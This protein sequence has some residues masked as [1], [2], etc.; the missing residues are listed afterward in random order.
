MKAIAKGKNG[1]KRTLTSRERLQRSVNQFFA[2]LNCRLSY[3]TVEISTENS[4]LATALGVTFKTVS[5]GKIKIAQKL[6]DILTEAE[7]DVVL[8]H[9]VSHIHLNHLLGTGFFVVARELAKNAARSD[10]QWKYLLTAWDINK[11]LTYWGG[12]LPPFAAVTKEQ[13]LDADASAV[14]L[15]DNKIAAHSALRKLV[16]NNLGTP[17]HTWEVFDTAIPVMTISER[18]SALDDR[19]P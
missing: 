16:G 7:V 11:A 5:F 2:R 12:D 3:V 10:P 8:A 9:E 6:L 17:S 1:F 15:T 18:L 4:V 13:E 19:F 14:F